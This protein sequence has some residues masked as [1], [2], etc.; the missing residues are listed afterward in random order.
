MRTLPA[1]SEF[2]PLWALDP[3]IVYL[4]HGSF[5]ACPAEILKKRDE[6]QQ[7]LECEPVRFLIREMETLFEHSRKKVAALAGADPGN[8]VFVQNATSGVN[9]VFRSLRFQPGDEILMT[10]HIYPACRR[11]LEFVSAQTGAVLVEAFYPFP[12][13][14]PG[15]IAEAILE[16]V[17]PR[18]RIALIDHITAATAMIQP[19]EEIVRELDR[20]GVDAMVDGAHAL[21]SVPLELEQLGAAYYTANCHKWLCAPKSAAILHVRRDKQDGIVPLVISHAGHLADSFTERFYW[22]GTYDPAAALCVG[23]AIDYM[24]SVFPGG[25]PAIMKRNHALCLEGR[26]I[27]CRLL[28]TDPPCP[29]F[30]LASM[31]TIPLSQAKNLQPV[32]YKSTV[33]LQDRLLYDAAIEMPVWYW[34][35]PPRRMIRISAQL[36][37]STEQYHYCGNVLKQQL[38]DEGLRTF[39]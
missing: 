27:L 30:M 8:L 13:S 34:S 20:L 12:L 1:A 21:G 14:D 23:D 5:G 16:K 4:N 37:N 35:E 38:M 17:T 22:P 7:R 19:V 31:A 24:A 39:L 26:N 9:T 6:Y 10:N 32:N 2:A 33:P 11:L 36:Y 3:A 15:L 29:D 18:T 25:W 28:E